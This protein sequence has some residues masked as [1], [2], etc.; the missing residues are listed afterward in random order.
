MLEPFI[1]VIALFAIFII[2]WFIANN[3][4]MGKISHGVLCPYC[5]NREVY[6][7]LKIWLITGAKYTYMCT[8]CSKL[9][10]NPYLECVYPQLYEKYYKE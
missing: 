2:L 3:L 1:Y 9:V 5:G 6:M 8:K 10:D 4:E 7:S